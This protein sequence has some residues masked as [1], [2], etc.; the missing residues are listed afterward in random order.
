M[1]TPQAQ[2]PTGH[3]CN[4]CKW[5]REDSARPC[6]LNAPPAVQAVRGETVRICAAYDGKDGVRALQE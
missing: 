2:R 4:A 3:I 6:A 1:N 5:Q